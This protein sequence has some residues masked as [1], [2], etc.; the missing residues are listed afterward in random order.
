MNAAAQWLRS[1]VRLQLAWSGS[2]ADKLPAHTCPESRSYVFVEATNDAYG[3]CRM[4]R[5]WHCWPIS[6]AA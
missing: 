1:Q 2:C 4:V 6:A 5:R 3:T